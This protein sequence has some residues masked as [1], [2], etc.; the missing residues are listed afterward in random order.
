[1]LLVIIDIETFSKHL[2]YGLY[3]IWTDYAVLSRK[4]RHEQRGVKW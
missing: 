3:I 1:M 4:G 2:M